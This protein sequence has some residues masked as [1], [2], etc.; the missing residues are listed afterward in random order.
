MVVVSPQELVYPTVFGNS[1]LYY[2][3][4]VS[5]AGDACI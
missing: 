5:Q 3:F 4:L 1:L 2:A